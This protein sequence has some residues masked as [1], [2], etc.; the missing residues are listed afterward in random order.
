MGGCCR[1]AAQTAREQLVPG[2]PP[3]PLS[4]APPLADGH[5]EDSD[6]EDAD[7]EPGLALLPSVPVAVLGPSPSSVVK[8]EA[9]EKAKKKKERQ[10][11]LGKGLPPRRGWRW[12]LPG[13]NYLGCSVCPRGSEPLRVPPTGPCRL[14]SPEGEV[15]IKRRPVKPGAGKLEKVPARRKAGGCEEGG[16]KKLKAKPK[17][18]LRAPAPSGPSAPTP[19]NSLFG[20]ADPRHFGARDDGARLA[21]ERLKKA[22]RKS[23]VLQSA[24]RVSA[25]WGGPGGSWG[26]RGL[27]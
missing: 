4:C 3:G 14:G 24:L 2:G 11:L 23:K 27:G 7:D 13:T 21:S 15:K 8:M 19:P 22:T 5:D 17:E 26:A 20:G 9:N 18:S 6:S 12:G 25:G 16:K 10:G 1:G